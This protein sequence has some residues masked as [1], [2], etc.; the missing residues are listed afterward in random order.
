M[1]SNKEIVQTHSVVEESRTVSSL[2]PHTTYYVE[3]AAKNP[4]FFGKPSKEEKIKTAA[5]SKK[6]FYTKFSLK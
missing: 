1:N 6:Y 4:D 5:G 2:Q 3:V